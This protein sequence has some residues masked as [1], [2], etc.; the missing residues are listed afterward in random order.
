MNQ[1]TYSEARQKLALV[2]EDAKKNGEVLIRRRDG[3]VFSLKPE[4]RD[5]S[6]LDVPGVSLNLRP[7]ESR[8]WIRQSRARSIL[9]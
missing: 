1:Y 7:G 4:S 2:L 3:S 8:K 6:P 5:Q 9:K